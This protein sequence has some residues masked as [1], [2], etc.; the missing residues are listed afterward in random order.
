M[1][2]SLGILCL[3]SVWIALGECDSRKG[4][5]SGGGGVGVGVGGGLLPSW[6]PPYLIAERFGSLSPLQ[7]MGPHCA[8]VFHSR[9]GMWID[10]CRPIHQF[11]PNQR[12]ELSSSGPYG[13][14]VVGAKYG[15]LC[16]KVD[17]S[18]RCIDSCQS[19]SVVEQIRAKWCMPN[20]KSYCQFFVEFPNPCPAEP[21]VLALSMTADYPVHTFI[22]TTGLLRSG[23]SY[24][25]TCESGGR[26]YSGRKKRAI[27][28][29]EGVAVWSNHRSC[30][31]FFNSKSEALTFSGIFKGNDQCPVLAPCPINPCQAMLPDSTTNTNIS[32]TSTHRPQAGLQ[33]TVSRTS[34]AAP[35][36]TGAKLST[37]SKPS[38]TMVPPKSPPTP[39][40]PGEKLSITNSA[41]AEG[42]S[43]YGTESAST[44]D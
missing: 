13:V 43:D 7:T 37:T 23:E 29:Y 33:T 34:P 14:S 26:P 10:P 25:C 6:V 44:V 9:Y 3:L 42:V 38:V 20:T 30:I 16:S 15:P 36:N 19:V 27:L 4:G 18:N 35:G 12:V 1:R 39:S 41:P 5:R 40:R 32:K 21:A 22:P 11:I 2:R 31:E 8:P 28:G 17:A 24:S